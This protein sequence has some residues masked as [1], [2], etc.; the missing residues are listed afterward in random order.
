VTI[1]NGQV[2]QLTK[3]FTSDEIIDYIEPDGVVTIQ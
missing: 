2:D 1:P 3:G